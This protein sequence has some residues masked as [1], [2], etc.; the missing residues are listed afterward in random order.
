MSKKDFTVSSF[1]PEL[2]H[3]TEGAS[4]DVIVDFEI[5][6][7]LLEK[8]RLFIETKTKT[9]TKSDFSQHFNIHV[10]GLTGHSFLLN[11]EK[12]FDNFDYYLQTYE[13]ALL[14]NPVLQVKNEYSEV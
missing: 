6:Q 12:L 11:K 2:A 8:S 3:V 14:A 4:N 13:F 7:A 5:I 9:K 1:Y 10:L